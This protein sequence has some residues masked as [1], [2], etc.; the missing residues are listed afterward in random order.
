MRGIL[1]AAAAAGALMLVGPVGVAPAQADTDNPNAS[2]TITCPALGGSVWGDIDGTA[3]ITWHD[4]YLTLN[5]SAAHVYS[6]TCAPPTH[7]ALVPIYRIKNVTTYVFNGNGIADCS[8]GFPSVFSCTYTTHSETLKYVENNRN[9][10][11]AS[12]EYLGTWRNNQLA[13]NGKFS[14]NT[15]ATLK[16]TANDTAIL[17]SIQYNAI[18]GG[19]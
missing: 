14:G 17:K 11:N 4:D 18:N 1:R 7:N 5:S 2:T 16:R 9:S 19:A 12:F 10:A 15:T 6:R 3:S 13:G 8:F